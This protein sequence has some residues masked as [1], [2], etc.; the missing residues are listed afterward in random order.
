MTSREGSESVSP[1]KPLKTSHDVDVIP[2]P[3]GVASFSLSS[4][5]VPDDA[6]PAVSS[7]LFSSTCY[8]LKYMYMLQFKINL[9]VII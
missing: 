3:S 7:A 4:V 5:V 8:N 9:Y 2:I 6:L 1:E